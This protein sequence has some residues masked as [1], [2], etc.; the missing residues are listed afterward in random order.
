[1]PLY[2]GALAELRRVHRDA[3]WVVAGV[4]VEGRF[5]RAARGV[6]PASTRLVESGL[7]S[8]TRLPD[9]IA[10]EGRAGEV[11]LG[12]ARSMAAD[13]ATVAANEVLL[14][15]PTVRIEDDLT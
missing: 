10:P 2:R 9:F 12:L 14:G 15:S 7:V 6:L 3:R 1:M 4:H 11:A 5:H 8:C 13:P